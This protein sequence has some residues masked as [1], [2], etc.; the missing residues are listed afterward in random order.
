MSC[1]NLSSDDERR[2]LDPGLKRPRCLWGLPSSG[3]F[4]ASALT[5]DTTWQR[6]H[7]AERLE[8]SHQTQ[9]IALGEDQ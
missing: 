7:V 5:V 1:G 8:E 6:I 9:L 3:L 2:R 4:H